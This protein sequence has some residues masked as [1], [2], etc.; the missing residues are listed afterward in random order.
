MFTRLGIV[1]VLLVVLLSACFAQDS[2]DIDLLSQTSFIAAE[3]TGLSVFG[4]ASPSLPTSLSLTAFPNPFNSSTTISYTLPKS[5]RTTM[6]V[7]DISGRLVTRLS[8]GWKEAGSY[9]E[10]WDGKGFT[11]GI[12]LV[13]IE[14]SSSSAT[15]KMLM[16]K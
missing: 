8:D 9:R 6:D 16:V 11:S 3:I 12:Y 5:G 4:D 14:M 13:R 15:K 2:L 7:V 10:V 1:A